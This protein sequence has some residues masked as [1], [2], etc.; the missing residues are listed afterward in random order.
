MINLLIRF[1]HNYVAL[2]EQEADFIRE[3]IPVQ[4]FSKGTILLEQG[5]IFDTSYFC[6]KGCA[7]MYYTRGQ[8]EKTAFFYTENQFISSIKSFSRRVPAK[9]S[10]QCL[11]D[12]TLAIIP[13]KVE[14]ELMERF[15]KIESFARMIMEEELSIY[16]EIVASFI[17]SGPEERY[18]NLMKN[19]PDLLNRIPQY[20]LASYLGVKAESLSRIRKRI[21][22]R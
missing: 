13:Y 17:T 6:L 8:E 19:R 3:N 18:H 15:P 22:S 5:K 1:V 11:E 20:Y 21:S 16:Q 7:R 12:T 10:F 4:T 2:N 14:N 9:H